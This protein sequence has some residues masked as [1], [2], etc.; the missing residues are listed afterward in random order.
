MVDN[1]ENTIEVVAVDMT[2]Y[3]TTESVS[4]DV[5]YHAPEIEGLTPTEDQYVNTGEGVKIEFDS[6]QGAR[7]TF[8]IHMPLT[9]ST[10]GFQ[11]ATE[12][13]MMEMADGHYVAYWTA[14]EAVAEGAVIEVIVQDRYG[15]ITREK[16]DGKLFINAE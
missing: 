13:P 10:G 4:I 14:T 5:K 3:S 1:G 8:V 7:A 2:G 12:L 6:E 16:A 11:N 15:N 9:N